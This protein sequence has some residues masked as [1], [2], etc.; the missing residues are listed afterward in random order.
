MALSHP[1]LNDLRM[2]RTDKRDDTNVLP[3][4]TSIIWRPL[5]VETKTDPCQ[6]DRVKRYKTFSKSG[7]VENLSSLDGCN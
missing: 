3:A 5:D 2:P 7:R 4:K 6:F 1:L